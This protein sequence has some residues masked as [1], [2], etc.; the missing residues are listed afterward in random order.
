MARR[1]PRDPIYRGCRFSAETIETCVRWYIT[2]RLSYRDLAEMMAERAIVVSHTTIM[3]WVLRYVPEYEQRWSR[4][5]R[6]PGS[7][8]RMDETAVSVRGGRHYLYRAVDR[9]G[10]SVASLLRNDR[11]MEAAQAFF[12]AAVSQDGVSWPEKINVDGNS[13]THRGL[14]LLAEEDHRWRAVEVRARRYLNNVVEQDHRAIKQR[15]AP[16]LGLKSFRS[17][18]ITLAGIELAHRIRKQQYLVP[19]G[20]GGQARSLKDSWAAAL[21]DSDVSVHGASARSAS[22]HQNSTARAGG[23]R[24]LPRVDGQVRYPRKIFL[25]GGLYLL[26]HP[27]GGRYWHYQYRYGDKRKT[28]SLG[29]YPDVPTALAQA[30]HRAAR[31]MLAAGVDPSLRRGELRRMDGGRPLAAVEVVGKR[32]Q[33]A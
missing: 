9:R 25:G 17:A 28:L 14:R 7:S 23:Q 8:W 21:R 12:R 2:Y 29:T 1:I 26:L 32:L 10:K 5:A 16:M 15:C 3:R 33:A 31:K 19:M 27:Q 18:A 11:S 24:T 30:R 20:E 22:M 13:A 6:S 4:F